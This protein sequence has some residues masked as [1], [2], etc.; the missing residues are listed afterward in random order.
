MGYGNSLRNLG[1]LRE[2]VDRWRDQIAIDP[3]RLTA[4]VDDVSHWS[5]LQHA[6]HIAEATQVCLQHVVRL[7]DEP[8]LVSESGGTTVTGKGILWSGYIPR[9][10][11]Q[12]PRRLQPEADVAVDAIQ[13]QLEH[14]GLLLWVNT[15]TA[16]ER[17]SA[18]RILLD[19]GGTDVH[20]HDFA[21]SGE[22]STHRSP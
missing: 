19:H 14:G 3:D 12:A 5:V 18:V 11:A 20:V 4:V 7:R 10:R 16:A 22:Q 8:T 9:G 21:E 2:V 1:Q 15:P 17:D 6:A 13:E